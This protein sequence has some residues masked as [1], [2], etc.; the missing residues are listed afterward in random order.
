MDIVSQI[1]HVFETIS[2]K[3]ITS[4]KRKLFLLNTVKNTIEFKTIIYYSKKRLLIS[5]LTLPPVYGKAQRKTFLD[6][7][8]VSKSINAITSCEEQVKTMTKFLQ[9]C[10]CFHAK[11]YRRIWLNKLKHISTIEKLEM[12]TTKT[13][14]IAKQDN[15]V[16]ID[17]ILANKW[18][19]QQEIKGIRMLAVITKQGITYLNQRCQPLSSSINK[20]FDSAL[21]QINTDIVLDG[22]LF[23][24][25]KLNLCKEINEDFLK[26]SKFIVFDSIPLDQFFTQ[27]CINTELK[28]RYCTLVSLFKTIKNRNNISIV[29]YKEH[30]TFNDFADFLNDSLAH[31]S[32]GLVLKDPKSSYYFSES[33][34]WV[35]INKFITG[36]FRCLDIIIDKHNHCIKGVK[37][38]IGNTITDITAG[39]TQQQRKSFYVNKTLVINKYIEVVYQTIVENKLITPRFTCVRYDV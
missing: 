36:V 3:Q 25:S 30:N 37:I 35:R 2:E 10:D 27:G 29:D 26:S 14:M 11:W 22:T 1:F 23:N 24:L 33:T 20:R 13:A 19:S 28:S 38:C 31:N 18:W 12:L 4:M 15:S 32:N 8:K 6:F 5:E 7:L 17:F 16:D 21:T 9:E 34:S 39:F